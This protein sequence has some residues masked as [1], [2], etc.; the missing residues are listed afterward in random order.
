M[1]FFDRQFEGL[2]ATFSILSEVLY[3]KDNTEEIEGAP[4]CLS[5]NLPTMLCVFYD[6]ELMNSPV[7]KEAQT[8]I[9]QS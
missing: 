3:T 7:R 8:A 6:L 9:I 4:T 2:L 1:K 5:S